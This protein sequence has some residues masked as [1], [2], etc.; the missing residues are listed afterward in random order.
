MGRLAGQSI[1][2]IIKGKAPSTLPILRATQFD[3][4]INYRAA[5]YIGLQL[6]KDLLKQANKI[7]R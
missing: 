5:N 3:L 6:P 4:T 7:I 1:D 2:Q